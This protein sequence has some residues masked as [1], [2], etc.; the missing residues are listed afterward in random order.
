MTRHLAERTAA[1]RSAAMPPKESQAYKNAHAFQPNR[2]KKVK[3]REKSALDTAVSASLAG[4]CERCSEQL[5][6]CVQCRR[7]ARED[8]PAAASCALHAARTHG[9]AAAWPSVAPRALRVLLRRAQ[10]EEVRQVPLGGGRAALVRRGAA[11]SRRPV[12]LPCAHARAL[13]QRLPAAFRQGRLPP[14]VPRRARQRVI[15][16]PACARRLTRCNAPSRALFSQTARA[17][18]RRAPSA[19]PSSPA[20]ASPPRRS[21]RARWR[22]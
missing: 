12:A 14:F 16:A 5:K 22:R 2:G 11:R 7:R 9:M 4:V 8:A 17:R 3:E 15:T 18:A 20:R 10:E 13:Q 21:K 6:W 1:P 19:T